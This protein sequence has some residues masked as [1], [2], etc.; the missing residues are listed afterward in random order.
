M[1]T[2]RLYAEELKLDV[3]GESETWCNKDTDDVEIAINGFTMYR[4]D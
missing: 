4:K 2:L 1:D 3:I